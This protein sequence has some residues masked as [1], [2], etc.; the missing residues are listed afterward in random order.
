MTTLDLI[1]TQL[2]NLDE[3]ALQEV[4]SLIKQ[5]SSR[6]PSLAE[7]LTRLQNLCQDE[8]YTLEIPDRCDRPNPFTTI[9]T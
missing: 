9:S 1:Q 8:N 4:Y 7:Q 6:P 3:S 5:L 2:P